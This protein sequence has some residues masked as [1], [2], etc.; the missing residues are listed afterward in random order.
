MKPTSITAAVPFQRAL[1]YSLTLPVRWW[2]PMKQD[3]DVGLQGPH[4]TSS[5]NWNRHL[6]L[7]DMSQAPCE[8]GWRTI[9]TVPLWRN[10]SR[11]RWQMSCKVQCRIGVKLSGW[12]GPGT[13]L[14]KSRKQSVYF[15]SPAKSK[16][17]LTCEPGHWS[18]FNPLPR[19]W[20]KCWFHAHY[21][22]PFW[23]IIQ[24]WHSESKF[25]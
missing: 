22:W 24:G 15:V 9:L 25:L 21:R 6:Y 1:P 17:R 8:E 12:K 19:P 14:Y 3:L 23:Y 7:A 5:L 2:C 4:R 16:G 11:I 13:K 10:V 18:Q 20:I